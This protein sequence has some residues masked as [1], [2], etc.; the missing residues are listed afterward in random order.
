MVDKM[1]PA[2]KHYRDYLKTPNTKSFFIQLITPQEFNDLIA[3]SDEAKAN[4]SY[5]IQVK[6]VNWQGIRFHCL[7]L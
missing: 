1:K 3:N 7:F 5:D 2:T 6:L 4:D